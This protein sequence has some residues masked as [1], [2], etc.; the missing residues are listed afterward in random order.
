MRNRRRSLGDGE[1]AG[2]VPGHTSAVEHSP[3]TSLTLPRLRKESIPSHFVLRGS[4]S[5]WARIALLFLKAGVANEEDLAAAGVDSGIPDGYRVVFHALSRWL[6]VHAG[7]LK[8]F[9][10]VV[11]ISIG[12]PETG[13]CDLDESLAENMVTREGGE[14]FHLSLA[15]SWAP[16]GGL[17]IF[18]LKERV[19]ALERAAPG[20]G[21]TTLWHLYDGLWKTLPAITPNS[22]LDHARYAYWCG[23]EDEATVFEEYREAGEDP[24]EILRKEDFDKIVPTWASSPKQRISLRQVKELSIEATE[25]HV[26]QVAG[27]LH[28]IGKTGKNTTLP[29]F[30]SEDISFYGLCPSTS[31][32]RWSEEDDV[33]RILDDVY[34]AANQDGTALNLYGVSTLPFTD[35]PA[36][37]SWFRR[38][39]KGLSLL[40]KLD[41]LVSCISIPDI[42][43][44]VGGEVEP[45]TTNEPFGRVA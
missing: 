21:E 25:R 12:M 15:E 45:R 32:L 28:E 27:L 4:I 36:L 16:E 39:E 26:R 37:K 22:A 9:R 23:E 41:A 30:W 34:N 24:P 8:A 31:I 13:N 5:S 7:G 18:Y 6:S 38:M 19:E 17:D 2:I 11:G 42:H 44:S 10:F 40:R 35:V 14:Y 43:N 20:L 33:L 29:N 1:S 3:A